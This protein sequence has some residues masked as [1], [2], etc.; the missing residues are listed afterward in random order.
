MTSSPSSRP[1][2]I[3]DCL[4]V[5]FSPADCPYPDVNRLLLATGFLPLRTQAGGNTLYTTPQRRGTVKIDQRA[6]FARISCS[7]AACEHLRHSDGWHEYLSILSESP[8]SVTR[9]DA[10]LD[11]SMDGAD[12]VASMRSMHP[13]EVSLGRKA[14]A[15]SVILSTREDGRESGT[16]YAGYGSSAKAT[17]KVY[18]KALQMLQRFGEVIPPRGRVEVTAL[19]D[20][21]ATLRDAALPEAIF[22]H[23]ASPALLTAPEGVPMW[24][25]NTD[26][27][28]QS[29][30]R[31]IVSAQV[32]KNRVENSGELDAFIELASSFEGGFDYLRHLL[33][34]RVDALD[35][36]A[37]AAKASKRAAA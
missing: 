2:I 5:T 37:I 29:E 15:T 21:G 1:L 25:P 35:P 17:A 4:D 32:L 26:G 16:W 6:R 20:Y 13:R 34:N 12:L 30:R 33:K 14:I 3:T 23:I 10:A 7:G 19:K 8:H 11:I 18:D 22:W 27:G 31:E 24:I 28:W 36:V 9:L